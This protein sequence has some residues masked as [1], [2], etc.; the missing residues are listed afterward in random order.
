MI[1]LCMLQIVDFKPTTRTYELLTYVQLLQTTKHKTTNF[2]RK[3]NASPRI[4]T[5]F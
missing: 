3:I 1:T 4:V 5:L 2:I